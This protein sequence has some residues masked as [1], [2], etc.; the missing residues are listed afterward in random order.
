MT[1][2]FKQADSNKVNWWM[3]KD[4]SGYDNVKTSQIFNG[5]DEL[6]STLIEPE[7]D[8]A[9]TISELRDTVEIEAYDYENMPGETNEYQ[10]IGARPIR[11]G[12]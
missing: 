4:E 1:R 9:D 6:V 7:N 8:D 11:P 12:A 3:C 5:S 10:R 2:Y